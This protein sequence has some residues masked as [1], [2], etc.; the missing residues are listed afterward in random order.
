MVDLDP[1]PNPGEKKTETTTTSTTSTPS[2]IS[3]ATVKLGSEIKNK[4]SGEKLREPQTSQEYLTKN[5]L[6]LIRHTYWF[7]GII[8]GLFVVV[9]IFKESTV[10]AIL[11]LFTLI[12]GGV[13]GM[14]S[15]SN[16]P[17]ASGN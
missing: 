12:I 7:M 17:S 9:A 2:K 13:I 8:L 15:K 4:I 16:Q 10:S 3:T 5:T 6:R 11:P 1:Q 14:I